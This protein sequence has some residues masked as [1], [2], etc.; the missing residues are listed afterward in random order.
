MGMTFAW[1]GSDS[2]GRVL[3]LT[4]E[5]NKADTLRLVL[6][7]NSMTAFAAQTVRLQA[8]MLG[9][10]AVRAEAQTAFVVALKDLVPLISG[11]GMDATQDTQV[12]LAQCGG[13]AIRCPLRGARHVWCPR[14]AIEGVYLGH[15]CD[16]VCPQGAHLVSVG[17]GFGVY[18]GHTC[19]SFG[20][21]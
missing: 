3:P 19:W 18:L 6:P 17:G 13:G 21:E 15:I 14:G 7:A 5:V 16:L 12:R 11:G 10:P 4:A 9:N 1:A 8:H 20:V 2:S